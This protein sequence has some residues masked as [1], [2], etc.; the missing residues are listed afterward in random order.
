MILFLK[1]ASFFA[2]K[3]LDLYSDFYREQKAKY[4]FTRSYCHLI[5]NW[6]VSK[7]NSSGYP[8]L[9]EKGLR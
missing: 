2:Y 8:V 7:D 6:I 4:Y 5:T 3:V 9:A 1:L